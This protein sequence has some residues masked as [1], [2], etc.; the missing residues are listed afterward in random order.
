MSETPRRYS[1]LA[2][3]RRVTYEDAYIAVPVNE[4]ILALRDDGTQGIDPD[5]LWAEAVRLSGDPRVE[6]SAESSVAAPH[7]I[8]QPL[9][10]SRRPFDPLADAEEGAG[11]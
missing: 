11:R 5:Q 7:P 2:R 6:W 8:Q 10:A 9:P 3:V 1:I 4:R